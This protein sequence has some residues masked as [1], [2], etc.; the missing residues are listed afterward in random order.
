[1]GASV[2]KKPKMKANVKSATGKAT[3][4]GKAKPKCKANVKGKADDQD[5]AQPH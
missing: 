3:L 4:K 1:M 5:Q 2:N